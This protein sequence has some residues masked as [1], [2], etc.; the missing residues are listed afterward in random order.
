MKITDVQI[1]SPGANPNT[2]IT[3][4]TLTMDSQDKTNPYILKKIIGLEPGEIVRTYNDGPK[5]FRMRPKDRVVGLSVKINPFYS[6]N[7][8]APG[9]NIGEL[10]DKI[11][12]IIAWN[13]KATTWNSDTQLQLRFMSHGTYIGSLFGF[14][15]KFDTDIFSKTTDLLLEITCDDPFIRDTVD[16]DLSLN[17]TGSNAKH[18]YFNGITYKAQS[19]F[20][21]FDDKST[22]PHGFKFIAEC[23]KVPPSKLNDPPKLII[24][25]SRNPLYYIFSGGGAFNWEV[26]D[27][28]HFSSEEDNRYFFVRRYW[29]DLS[30]HD[31]S[32]MG[33]IYWGSIWPMVARGENFIEIS[34][35]FKFKTVSHR[36]S[37][38]GV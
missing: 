6:T 38:W 14:V 4:L 17:I 19:A 1:C 8:W 23:V 18:K 29:W 9:S 11:Y 32:L 15:S 31:Y 12:N 36:Y 2:L 22:A 30:E 26:G 10:R 13:S 7:P 27:M 5:F 35:G 21:C 20:T 3:H 37:Y 25:D 28:V 33:D 16:T 24:W 34:E